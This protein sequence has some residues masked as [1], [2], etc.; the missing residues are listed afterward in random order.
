MKPELEERLARLGQTQGIGR[1]SSGSPVDLVLRVADGLAKVKTITAIEALARRHMPLLK[2]KRAIEAVVETG[3]ALVH[4]PMVEDARTLAG[5]LRRAGIAA[6]RIADSAVDVKAVRS[7]LDLTQEQFALRYG[8]DIDAVQNWEQGRCK[9]DKATASY[10]RAI[11]RKPRE[12]AEA[13]EETVV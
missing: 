13:Q 8:L 6:M 7:A 3:E 9:P 2:S 1:V 12:L 11:A 5:D 4:V 10:L